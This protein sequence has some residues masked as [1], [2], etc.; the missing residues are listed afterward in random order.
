M[1]FFE[2]LRISGALYGSYERAVAGR[3]RARARAFSR[4][5]RI[6]V[7]FRRR[8]D[9]ENEDFLKRKNIIISSKSD[10]NTDVLAEDGNRVFFLV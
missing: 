9:G 3:R 5:V 7:R 2:F 10:P 6:L 4:N 8:R 1:N